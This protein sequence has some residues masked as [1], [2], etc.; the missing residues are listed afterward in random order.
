MYTGI[1]WFIIVIGACYI[2][3]FGILGMGLQGR[4][5][6]RMISKIGEMPARIIYSLIG[7]FAILAVVL[8]WLG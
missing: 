2:V 4:R 8:G 1:E 6:Q 7:L 5:A 3:F